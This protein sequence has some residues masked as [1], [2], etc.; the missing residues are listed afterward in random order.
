MKMRRNPFVYLSM[1]S[2]ISL[3]GL[4]TGNEGWYGFLGFLGWL[5]LAR[6]PYDERLRKNVARAS[7]IGF[8]VSFV[9]VLALVTMSGLGLPK[10]LI[11]ATIAALFVIMVLGFGIS[12]VIFERR[13]D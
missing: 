10:A 5:G 6:T 7:Q 2:L 12:V 11:D 13:G 3:L 8:M 9:G 4:I 1:L